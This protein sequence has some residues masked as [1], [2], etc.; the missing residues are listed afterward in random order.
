[1]S[2]T[3][4]AKHFNRCALRKPKTQNERRSSLMAIDAILD[5]GFE[6]D[7]R[8]KSTVTRKPTAWD[9][10]VISAYFELY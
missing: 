6:P 5:A 4:R 7:N 3:K 2:R 1:M 8:L 9:D 10:I